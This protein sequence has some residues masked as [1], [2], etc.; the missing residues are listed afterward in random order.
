MHI[1]GTKLIAI[2][3]QFNKYHYKVQ[4]NE[5]LKRAF[6]SQWLD[7]NEDN[8]SIIDAL[9]KTSLLYIVGSDENDNNN[10]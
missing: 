5:K 2:G 3:I 9:K 10:V 4:G 7:D 6:D 8:N 1:C